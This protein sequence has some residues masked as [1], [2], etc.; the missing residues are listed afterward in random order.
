MVGGNYEIEF[1]TYVRY[2]FVVRIIHHKLPIKI[3]LNKATEYH[4]IF[5]PLLRLQGPHNI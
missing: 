2:S 1:G 3:P 4:M 5:A